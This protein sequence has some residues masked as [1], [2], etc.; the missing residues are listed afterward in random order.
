M[1]R[2]FKIGKLIVPDPL[3]NEPDLNKVFEQLVIRFEH[4]R[5]SSLFESDGKPNPDDPNEIIYTIPL[6]SKARTNG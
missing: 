6:V 2:K 5:Y 3:P 1:I 4:C